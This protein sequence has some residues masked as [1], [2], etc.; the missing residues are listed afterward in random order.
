MPQLPPL[1]ETEITCTRQCRNGITTYFRHDTHVGKYL[2]K[3]G[4]FSQAEISLFREAI[5]PGNVVIEAG[6]NIGCHTQF[7]ALATGRAGHVYA[8]EPQRL[9]FQALCA[10]IAT[11]GLTN[12]TAYP[13]GLGKE[14][15]SVVMPEPPI[16]TETNIGGIS[17]EHATRQAHAIPN[18]F[19]LDEFQFPQVNFIKIDVEGMELDVLIGGTETIRRCRPIMYIENDRQD[20]SEALLR[21]LMETLD[22]KLWWHLPLMY[23]KDNF[24]GDSHDIKP[25]MVS[26]NV[27]ALPKEYPAQVNNFVPILAP[28]DQ[29]TIDGRGFASWVY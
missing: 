27:F 7:F 1:V 22:Y 4:E 14:R 15:A 25:G 19:S 12:V 18:I 6:A 20:R 16:Q 2:E 26:V 29:P 8:F 9:V 24:Y 3:Y 23:N 13:Y 11:N 10:N 5:A 21:Y 17:I 28:T